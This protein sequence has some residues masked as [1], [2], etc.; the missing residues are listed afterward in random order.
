MKKLILTGSIAVFV[1]AISSCGHTNCDAYG[2][3]SDY[4][5]YKAEKQNQVDLTKVVLSKIKK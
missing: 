1:L 4:T 5:K 2:G 3:Q